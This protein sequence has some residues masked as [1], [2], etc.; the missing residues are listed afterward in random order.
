MRLLALTL[1]VAAIACTLIPP[2]VSQTT[3]QAPVVSGDLEV[4]ARRL[5]D[6]K[7]FRNACQVC[8]RAAD[9]KLSCSNIGIACNPSGEWRCS[10]PATLGGQKK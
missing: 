5:P 10:I 9:G 4:L 1:A 2:A 8:V 7:E 6:C 3:E